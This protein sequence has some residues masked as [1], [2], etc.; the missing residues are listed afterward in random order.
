MSSTVHGAPTLG[1]IQEWVSNRNINIH[2]I[3]QVCTE[4]MHHITDI[5]VVYW[6]LIK[7]WAT[8]KEG[9]DL[10]ENK[11]F[12]SRYAEFRVERTHFR[13]RNP[14][15]TS[16]PVSYWVPC[17]LSNSISW[18]IHERCMRLTRTQRVGCVDFT[19]PMGCVWGAQISLSTVKLTSEH[20]KMAVLAHLSFQ[21]NDPYAPY[22]TYFARYTVS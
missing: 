22:N 19:N 14:G 9:W 6:Q 7:K 16:F 1:I 3:R 11:N 8:R 2:I 20:E 17:T 10:Q 18:R 4:S 21:Q 13:V 12:G 15:W 5:I